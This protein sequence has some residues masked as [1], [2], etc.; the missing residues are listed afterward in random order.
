MLAKICEGIPDAL[1]QLK[2]KG[3]T[4]LAE[5]KYDGQRAQIH[6]LPD[7]SVRLLVAPTAFC[8]HRSSALRVYGTQ[9]G[10]SGFGFTLRSGRYASGCLAVLLSGSCVLAQVKVF[11]RNCEER[12]Q[13]FPDVANAI[14]A[15]AEGELPEPIQHQP[16]QH[17]DVLLRQMSFSFWRITTLNPAGM[18]TYSMHVVCIEQ[19]P[20]RPWC[21]TRSWWRWTGRT[22][23]G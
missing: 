17:A 9:P 21:W 19:G 22:T 14:R 6:L 5:Y 16:S 13:S 18:L 10:F 15:A 2:D 23:T 7:G 12:T 8:C 1:A 11:S 20:R 3:A 4:F